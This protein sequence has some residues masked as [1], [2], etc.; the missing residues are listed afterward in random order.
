MRHRLR[1]LICSI[2]TL[3]QWYQWWRFWHYALYFWPY[4][5]DYRVFS[6]GIR[7]VQTTGTSD[8]DDIHKWTST[9]RWCREFDTF[10]TKFSWFVWKKLL[11][12]EECQ[13]SEKSMEAIHKSCTVQTKASCL[14]HLTAIESFKHFYTKKFRILSKCAD[15]IR[16][17]KNSTSLTKRNISLPISFPILNFKFQFQ[18]HWSESLNDT[19]SKSEGLSCHGIILA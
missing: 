12:D 2:S 17:W 16:S 15:I 3:K 4:F 11:V 13:I 9:F 6:Q 10:H 18:W 1:V 5:W 19:L 7:P 8:L 14:E